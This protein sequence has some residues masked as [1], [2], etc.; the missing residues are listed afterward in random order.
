MSSDKNEASSQGDV[1]DSTVGDV[2]HKSSTKGSPLL[3]YL[4]VGAGVGLVG[5]YFYN[6]ANSEDGS[7]GVISAVMRSITK[8][9]AGAL[10]IFHRQ[11]DPE[12][13]HSIT[14]YAP[15]LGTLLVLPVNLSVDAIRYYL[16]KSNHEHDQKIRELVESLNQAQAALNH[17]PEKYFAAKVLFEKSCK[18]YKQNFKNLSLLTIQLADIYYYRAIICFSMKE[19]ET[20]IQAET[21][22]LLNKALK[23]DPLHQDSLN[24]RGL[25]HVVTNQK[26]LTGDDFNTS[27]NHDSSQTAIFILKCFAEGRYGAA[28]VYQN[29]S[30]DNQKCWSNKI[31]PLILYYHA[32]CYSQHAETLKDNDQKI[33]QLNFAIELYAA[34]ADSMPKSP[35]RLKHYRLALN[36]QLMTMQQLSDIATNKHFP[37]NIRHLLR[38]ESNESQSMLVRIFNKKDELLQE[39]EKL[40][41]A[42]L[43]FNEPITSEIPPVLK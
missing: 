4:F 30:Y 43:S 24:L 9:I 14:L 42:L 21:L 23:L 16:A 1:L 20:K 6:K 19:L 34:A 28:C 32:E 27:L 25:L 7:G 37:L 15:L 3:F 5:Y 2:P 22:R 26:N 36:R 31:A 35:A 11:L 39:I 17:G 13:K 29:D 8:P 38:F 18:L 33:T 10:N 41:Y 12:V 40:E